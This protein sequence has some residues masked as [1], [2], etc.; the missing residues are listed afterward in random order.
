[1]FSAD[2]SAKDIM[3][4]YFGN[5]NLRIIIGNKRRIKECYNIHI[6]KD[7]I[8]D[9][10]IVDMD[11]IYKI[12]SELINNQKISAK[13]VAMAIHGQDIIVRH[14][15]IPIMDEKNMRSAIEWEV[16]QFLPEDGK[17]HYID[18]Q[19]L[20]KVI[21]NN[22]KVYN[23]LTVAVPKEKIDSYVNL[24]KMLGLELK[25]IDIAANCTAR[26]FKNIIKMDKKIESIGVIEIGSKASSIIILDKGKLFMEREVPFGVNNITKEICRKL[27]LS[28]EEALDYFINNI[29]VNNINEDIEIEKRVQ[30]LLDNVFSSF[31]KIIQFY[32]TGKVSKKLDKIYITGYS[33][34]IEG[35]DSYI[36]NYFKADVEIPVSID[37]LN[38]KMK[39]AEDCNLSLYISV[40]GLLLRKE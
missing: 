12:I 22:K 3:A 38:I 10:K 39:A 20:D 40:L 24:S 33:N 7:S 19:V 32:T 27:E 13:S 11:S 28:E 14:I 17:D 9:G 36:M 18:F 34:K 35:L 30:T 15:N 16:N 37:K 29:D 25:C 31:I 21:D 8:N 26:V 1:M 4:I 6:P 2:I 23:L 5:S